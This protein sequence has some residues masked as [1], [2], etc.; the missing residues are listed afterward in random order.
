MKAYCCMAILIFISGCAANR[1]AVEPPESRPIRTYPDRVR[2]GMALHARSPVLAETTVNDPTA[3]TLAQPLTGW[4]APAMS[5]T[6]AGA[7]IITGGIAPADEALRFSHVTAVGPRSNTAIADLPARVRDALATGRPN[8][9]TRLTPERLERF[10]IEAANG[11]VTLRGPVRSETERLMISQRV[12]NME[13]VRAVNNQL[14]VISPAG[15]GIADPI[16]P[17]GRPTTLLREN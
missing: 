3:P 12:A 13:G 17:A 1:V 11:V 15:P 10:E 9:I 16:E 4:G 2:P 14:R 5:Q 7:G 6:S 8:S